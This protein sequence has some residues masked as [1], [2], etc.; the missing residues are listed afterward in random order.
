MLQ[1]HLI[2][3]HPNICR[4]VVAFSGAHQWMKK[5]AVN[6]LKST[7]LNIFVS[8]VDRVTGLEANN[9]VPALI[10]KHQP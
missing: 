3:A 4:D 7:F 10:G 1:Q 5:E 2:A 6:N 8:A 9:G